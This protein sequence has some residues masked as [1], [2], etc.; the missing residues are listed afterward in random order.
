[1]HISF[2]SADSTILDGD[3]SFLAQLLW[4]RLKPDT[5]PFSLAQLPA[6]TALV[7]GS[8]RDGLLNRLQEKPD[9]DL[10]VPNNAIKISQ[11]FA[12]ELDATF[13]VLDADRDMARVVLKGWTIDIAKQIGFDLEEDLWRRD[14]RINAIALTLGPSPEIFDPTGG[15]QDLHQ[16]KLVAVREKN[17]FEDPLRTLRGMRF[18]GELNLSLD[19]Q[20]RTFINTY[21]GLLLKVAPERIQSEVQRIVCAEHADDA[22]ELTKEIGLLDF[23]GNQDESYLSTLLPWN[24]HNFLKNKELSVALPL[25]R[26]THL[27]SD[28]GLESLRFSKRQQQRCKLLRK[29]QKCNDGNDFETLNEGDRLQL[30]KDLEEDLPALILQLSAKNQEVW[31]NRWR[32]FKDPLFHPSSPVDGHTLQDIFDLP[33]GPKLGALMNHLSHEKAFDR[34]QTLEETLKEARHWLQHN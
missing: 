15:I 34:L 28:A 13:V 12:K 9:L 23:W 18:I 16:K 7:G 1:M 10:V 20:T 22:I 27:L 21:A 17:F 30:H 8:V 14:F 31:I 4:S 33:Q 2:T 19:P 24:N 32:D 6:G 5:W 3:D 29:W 11:D 25:V 26:L